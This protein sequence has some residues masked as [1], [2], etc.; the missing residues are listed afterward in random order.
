MRVRASPLLDAR[1]RAQRPPSPRCRRRG[2]GVAAGWLRRWL[3]RWPLLHWPLRMRFSLS[4]R[5][6]RLLFGFSFG[7]LPLLL[8]VLYGQHGF[9]AAS[10]PG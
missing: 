1:A 9:I 8:Q 6:L 4:L 5:Q 3:R 2:T 7:L 10:C